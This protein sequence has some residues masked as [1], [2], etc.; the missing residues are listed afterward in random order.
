MRLVRH[1]HLDTHLDT[2]THNTHTH[3]QTRA[4][5]HTHTHTR[6]HVH[7]HTHISPTGSWSNVP[8]AGNA[9]VAILPRH[10]RWELQRCAQA[11]DAAGVHTC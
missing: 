7:I 9:G 1:T 10:A 3:T 5:T 6:Q 2:H 4:H 8:P 11:Q